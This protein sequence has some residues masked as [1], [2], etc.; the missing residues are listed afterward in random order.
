MAITEAEMS[1]LQPG[2]KIVVISEEEAKDRG[3]WYNG[4][5]SWAGDFD[6]RKVGMNE[7]CG[8]ELTVYEAEPP[9]PGKRYTKAYVKENGFWWCDDFI[10]AIV[11]QE[12]MEPLEPEVIEA[13]LFGGA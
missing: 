7:Y 9:M 12:M 1:T 2:D 11:R 8:E 6:S 10:A 5:A 4:T 3:Y 13:M